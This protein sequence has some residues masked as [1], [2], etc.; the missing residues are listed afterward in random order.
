MF[1]R[2]N[3]TK[4]TVNYKCALTIGTCL[5]KAEIMNYCSC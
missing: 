2:E 1:L 4:L 3:L 5:Y